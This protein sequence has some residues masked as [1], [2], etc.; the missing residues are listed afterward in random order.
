MVHQRQRNEDAKQLLLVR[1][2]YSKSK[3]LSLKQKSKFDDC[4][5]KWVSLTFKADSYVLGYQMTKTDNMVV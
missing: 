1:L 3:H 5:L 2:D 4:A